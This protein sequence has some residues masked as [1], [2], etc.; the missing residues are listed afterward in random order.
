[1]TEHRIGVGII[2]GSGYGAGELLRLLTGHPDC[3]VV[4]VVSHSHAGKPIGSMHPHL[5]GFYPLTFDAD[6]NL[7]ALQNFEHKVVFSAL[8][9]GASARTIEGLCR[10][11]HAA[12][13]RIIDLSGDFRLADGGAHAR[14]Y[15]ESPELPELRRTFCYGLPELHADAIKASTHIA[16][17]GCYATACILSV[18]PLI[19]G[20][21]AEVFFDAKSGS[22]GAGRGL[23][24]E[25]HHPS[26]HA[27]VAAYKVLAHRHEPEI[28]QQIGAALPCSFV[29]QLIPVSRGIY[30]T[31]HLL[32]QEE[33]PFDELHSRYE[34]FYQ[35][36]PFVRLCP[37]SPQL[38]A[39]VGSNFCDIG[40]A[41]RGRRVVVMA[42]LDNLIKGM[43]GQAI[44]NLNLL[45][46]L[47]QDRGLRVP[48][49]G[50]V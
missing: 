6:L 45:C 30:V 31:A 44:Q 41:V 46:G 28:Q 13:L 15:P 17:P 47:P 37:H 26:L 3:G 5:R 34:R 19:G 50:L 16:N 11:P 22:S 12:G 10:E 14:H 2:G 23:S 24:E 48:A 29:P 9:H 4:S 38:G 42:V 21:K 39:V 20:T 35:H 27:N 7:P 18:A 1:M 8:P 32:L 40:L 36:A 43:A 25:T 49:I 33:L